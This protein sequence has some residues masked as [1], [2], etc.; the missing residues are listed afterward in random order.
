MGSIRPGP[1]EVVRADLTAPLRTLTIP[2]L[3]LILITGV[4][5]MGVGWLDQPGHAFGVDLRNGVV[6][7]WALL[8][9][10]RFVVPLLRARRR[11]FLVTDRRIIVRDGT[12]RSRV[13]SIPLQDVRGVQRRRNGISLAILG[14]DRPLFFP[15][16]PRTK[17]VASLIEASLPPVPVR[18]W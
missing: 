2:T 7:V 5:W 11:R 17:K 8:V 16:V 13:D 15:D 4:C 9:L 1:G 18:Y 6:G 3:E 12:F 14:F 10:W